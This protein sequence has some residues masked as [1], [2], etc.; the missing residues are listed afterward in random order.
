MWVGFSLNIEWAME[1]I[2]SLLQNCI[3]IFW[4]KS[5]FK[6]FAKARLHQ[7]KG[8]FMFSVDG[9]FLKNG[10]LTWKTGIQFFNLLHP[11]ESGNNF[12]VPIPL[13]I[14]LA[15][16]FFFC[17]KSGYLKNRQ[18]LDYLFMLLSFFC[19]SFLVH[20]KTS[21]PR[22]WSLIITPLLYQVKLSPSI[23]CRLTTDEF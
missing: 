22:K 2:Y 12:R 16:F 13:S 18:W 7:L 17:C 14:F 23:Y 9:N 3:T 19:C 8:F 1:R 21:F 5:A 4:K 10:N 20:R 11:E 15:G 6:G